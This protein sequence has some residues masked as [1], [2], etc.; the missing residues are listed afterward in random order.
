MSEALRA[1]KLTIAAGARMLCRDLNLSIA[2]GELWVVL[3]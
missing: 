3:G 1:E 2:P